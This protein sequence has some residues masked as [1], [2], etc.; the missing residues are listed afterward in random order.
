M[1]VINLIMMRQMP[2]PAGTVATVMEIVIVGIVTVVTMA[3][4]VAIMTMGMAIVAMTVGAAIVAVMVGAAIVID[5]IETVEI[6][7]VPS[8]T[9]NVMEQQYVFYNKASIL[10]IFKSCNLCKKCFQ[11][12]PNDSDISEKTETQT[13]Q[14]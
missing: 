4:I 1:S 7:V 8:A 6:G 2:V 3:V 10:S 11:M 9:F 12:L 14:T 13:C 5:K